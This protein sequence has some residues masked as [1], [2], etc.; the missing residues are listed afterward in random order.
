VDRTHELRGEGTGWSLPISSKTSLILFN[1]LFFA[2]C[3]AP[4][5]DAPFE[6]T[7]PRAE[8]T[9]VETSTSAPG[10]QAPLPD[11]EEAKRAR[12][13]AMWLSAGGAPPPDL[14]AALANVRKT[15]AD[16]AL[17]LVRETLEGPESG[18]VREELADLLTRENT[19]DLLWCAAARTAAKLALHEVT[20][21]VAVNLESPSAARRVAAREVLFNLRGEWFLTTSEAEANIGE[22]PPPTEA[23]LATLLATTE[24]LWEHAAAL[25]VLDPAWATAALSDPDPQLRVAAA[26]ALDEALALP[27]P[28]KDFDPDR[29]RSALF[30]RLEV[31]EHPLVLYVLIGGFLERL[32]LTDKC[33]SDGREFAGALH[34][35]V[36]DCDFTMLAPLVHGLTRMPLDPGMKDASDVCSLDYT[37]EALFGD[38][39]DS[40]EMGMLIEWMRPGRLVDADA[41]ASALRSLESFFERT[42]PD[43]SRIGL[44]EVLLETIDDPLRDASIRAGSARV[45][46]YVGRPEDLPRLGAALTE[47]PTGVAYELIGT[48]TKLVEEVEATNESAIAAGRDAFIAMILHN[49]ASL[50]RRALVMLSTDPLRSFAKTIDAGLLLVVLEQDLPS[51]DSETIL[52][53]LALRED[54]SLVDALLSSSAFDRLVAPTSGTASILTDTLGELAAGDGPL[55]HHVARQLIETAGSEGVQHLRNALALLAALPESSARNLETDQHADVVRWSIELREAAGT[56]A[57]VTAEEPPIAFLERLTKLHLDDRDSTSDEEPWAHRRALL[58]ADLFAALESDLSDTERELFKSE[59]TPIFHRARVRAIASKD[60]LD[61]VIVYRD[62]ARFLFSADDLTQALLYYGIVVRE[63]AAH[64]VPVESTILDLADLRR[65]AICADAGA[66]AD[67]ESIPTALDFTLALVG[68]K[69]WK[70]EPAGVRL[71]DLRSLVARAGDTQAGRAA[72]FEVLRFTDLPAPDADLADAVIPA[73]APWLGLETD[74]EQLVELRQLAVELETLPPAPEEPDPADPPEES[75]TSEEVLETASEEELESGA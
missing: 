50:R 40:G 42:S 48:I 75:E 35:R 32:G 6:T 19:D 74:P 16:I 25:Y 53:L 47:A 44:R 68:R 29:A 3:T 59:M 62:F 39:D 1:A 4:G 27:D 45:L 7:P 54:P 38:P 64:A 66:A 56:L 36:G 22:G 63:E 24:R 55:T 70:S 61:E 65:A 51:E 73:D 41:L 58:R 23:Q 8:P 18:A 31:E 14:S 20:S 2:G 49:E 71:G 60:Q 9:G 15:D 46:V 33:T 21:T 17:E 5:A 43:P 69:Y 72:L 13:Y 30:E 28:P 37:A 12:W 67:P 26:R 34:A 57:G 52:G 10:L 11:S